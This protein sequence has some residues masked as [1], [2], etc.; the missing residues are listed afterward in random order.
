MNFKILLLLIVTSSNS[1]NF[2]L[3]KLLKKKL[4]TKKE[5]SFNLKLE[6]EQLKPS[7]ISEYSNM[8]KNFYIPI[9]NDTLCFIYV[10]SYKKF[11]LYLKISKERILDR[12]NDDKNKDNFFMTNISDEYLL[13]DCKKKYMFNLKTYESTA[14]L[15]KQD[16]TVRIN[17]PSKFQSY[18]SLLNENL[19][20][21]KHL[22]NWIHDDCEFL[23]M[24]DFSYSVNMTIRSYCFDEKDKNNFF[25]MNYNS[26][27]KLMFK[28]Y[29]YHKE[30]VFNKYDLFNSLCFD[31]Y[32][33][34]GY[35]VKVN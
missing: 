3:D 27:L 6:I 4:L 30:E 2:S 25:K 18:I 31:T 33:N 10:S 17:L 28:S 14:Y 7:D 26:F 13:I 5:I 8:E 9:K 29:L 22:S 19:F 21:I 20:P 24:M 15:D 16:N 11:R 23:T 34:N 32:Y 12:F 1:Q 35:L